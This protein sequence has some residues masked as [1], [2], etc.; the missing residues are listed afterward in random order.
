MIIG[1][2]KEIKDN[3]YRV[4]ATP[5]GIHQLTRDGH[6]VL[7]QTGA[8]VGSGFSDEE[9]AEAGAELVPEAARLW[10]VAEMIMKVKEP[11]TQEYDHLR[12]GL[13]LYTYLHLA[14]N[15]KLT[16]ELMKR[17]VTG[18][19][20]ETVESPNG[21]LPLLTPMSEVAGKMAVQIGAHYLEKM[22]GG[23][24]KLLGGIPG[25]LAADVVILGGGTVG[26]NAAIVALGMG[27]SVLIVD[28]NADRLRYL[29]EVLHG[30]LKT[31]VSTP[32]NIA[33]ALK[34][35]DLVIGAVLVKGAKAPKLV[36]KQMVEEMKPGSVMV[37][38][39]VDQGGCFET[40]RTTSHSQPTYEINGVVHYCVPNIPGAVPRTSTYGL[41]NVTLPYAVR[42]ANLGFAA[43]VAQDPTLAKGV[44]TYKGHVTYKAVAEAFDIPYRPLSEL[45]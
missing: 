28:V 10:S 34:R 31:L 2:P 15:E 42:L 4:A 24:G 14:A 32:R 3:E 21:A 36:T 30:S 37:D 33:E 22:N 40:T 19:A 16:R 25:V 7:V 43:A 23:R 18:V 8:G 9:Y 35:A 12:E 6:R 5:G 1:V 11:L 26:T 44:N 29:T 39:A 13:I 38:V 20:Y 41:S 17:K 45:L 27:A